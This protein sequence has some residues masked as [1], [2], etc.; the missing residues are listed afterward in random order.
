[1]DLRD[2]RELTCSYVADEELELI[3]NRRQLVHVTGRVIKDA[4][5]RIKSIEEV[6]KI[7]AV[8]LDPIV[9]GSVTTRRGG[10]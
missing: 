2:N 9:V 3:E 10:P 5:G 4:S 6:D 8:N 1:M 7:E